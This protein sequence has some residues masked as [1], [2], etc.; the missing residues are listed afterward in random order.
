MKKH[1]FLDPIVCTE[2]KLKSVPVAPRK[3]KKLTFSYIPEVVKNISLDSE[4]RTVVLEM[5][6]DIIRKSTKQNASVA[7]FFSS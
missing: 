7:I 1:N 2:T 5:I 6:F 3:F 4:A